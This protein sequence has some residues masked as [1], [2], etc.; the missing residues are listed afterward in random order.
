MRWTAIASAGVVAFVLLGALS[1][2]TAV[3][4]SFDHPDTA[5]EPLIYTQTSPDLPP[6]AS[7]IVALSA[8]S[9]GSLRIVVEETAG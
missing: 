1:V 7:R 2:R 4:V 6:L 5:V 8:A 3:R 9:G